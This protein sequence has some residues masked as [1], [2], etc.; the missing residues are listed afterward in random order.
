MH[1]TVSNMQGKG[2]WQPNKTSVFFCSAKGH[3]E[4]ATDSE[5]CDWALLTIWKIIWQKGWNPDL[6]SHRNTVWIWDW[7]CTY[8]KYK[9]VALDLTH[10]RSL[11]G[12][13][14]AL[15]YLSSRSPFG[16]LSGLEQEMT[17][18]SSLGKS[19]CSVI[20]TCFTHKLHG[21]IPAFLAKRLWKW[22]MLR[23]LEAA[24]V[25]MSIQLP[26]FI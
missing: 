22:Q 5:T 9:C 7:K 23:K 21:S 17:G 11:N 3:K 14:L 26:M 24:R 19:W 1:G 18:Y 20:G 25:R 8:L 15:K 6:P 16:I 12:L 10:S 13:Q 2:T 4:Q